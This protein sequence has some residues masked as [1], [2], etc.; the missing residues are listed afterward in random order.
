MYSKYLIVA[1]KKDRAG[2]NITTQLSQFPRDN[3]NFYLVEDH[4]IFTENL[5]LEKINKYDLIIFASRHRSEK[6]EKTLSVHAPGNWREARFGGEPEKVSRSSALFQKQLFERLNEN[7]KEYRLNEK[8]QVTSECTHHGPLLDK[9]CVFIEI[10]SG[11][12]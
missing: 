9:P 1:S 12:E 2:I 8:Y 5:D 3:F 7:V 11:P 6:G 4:A 10:G